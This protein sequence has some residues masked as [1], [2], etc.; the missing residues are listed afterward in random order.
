MRRITL[1]TVALMMYS[2]A[3]FADS[4]W[5]G[6][7]GTLQQITDKGATSTAEISV[8]GLRLDY[9]DYIQF[10]TADN[11]RMGVYTAGSGTGTVYLNRGF[12]VSDARVDGSHALM[13]NKGGNGIGIYV[14]KTSGAGPG[15]YSEMAVGTT[16]QGFYCQGSDNNTCFYGITGATG[17]PV[18]SLNA[19]VAG[20][21]NYVTEQQIRDVTSTGHHA[22]YK[23]SKHLNDSYSNVAILSRHGSLA[24]GYDVAVG[25][26]GSS[27]VSTDQNVF[28]ASGSV[29]I[30]GNMNATGTAYFGGLVTATSGINFGASGG[31]DTLAYY[32]EGTWTPKYDGSTQA[33]VGCSYNTQDGTY[34]K[35]G[36]VIFAMAFVNVGGGC[37]TGAAGNGQISGLPFTSSASSPGSCSIGYLSAYDGL[38]ANEIMTAFV[39]VNSTIIQFWETDATGAGGA[40]SRA[41]VDSNDTFAIQLTCT[42]YN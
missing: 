10:G 5:G 3:A 13:V 1:I 4:S 28:V 14:N 22:L 17:K 39:P 27:L 33:T 24:L 11:V 20:F 34:T 41:A 12:Y 23:T 15:I 25:D 16:G 9:D 6:G 40:G 19:Y 35:I 36:N 18:L 7:A 31:A 2:C 21:T 26:L 8:G 29:G 42:Y 37:T 32:D 38:S 30:K